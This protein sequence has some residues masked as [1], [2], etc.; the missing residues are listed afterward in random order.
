MKI[1][2][3]CPRIPY[4]PVDGG[5]LGLYNLSKALYLQNAE[6]TVLAFNTSKHFVKDDQIS[7][8]YLSTH[9]LHQV[10][11]DN[12]PT[13]LSAIINL[14]SNQS[15]HISRFITKDFEEKLVS[16]LKSNSFDIIQ[17]D[18]LV[19]AA[20]IDVIRKHSNAK[21]VLRAHNVEY[22]IWKRLA[23]IEANILKR[24]YLFIL[25]K[26]LQDFETS[27]LSKVDAIVALTEE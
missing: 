2:Q 6:I 22:R 27:V 13:V 21:V 19:M 9:H 3:L 7:A 14:F 24:K 18:Y 15:Y 17:V 23:E 1:L 11:L 20:Y 12:R 25:A 5:T 16:L 4:P 10:Y 8:E 26:R